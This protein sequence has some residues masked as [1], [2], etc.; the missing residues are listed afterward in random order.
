MMPSVNKQRIPKGRR[1][2]EARSKDQEQK[3]AHLDGMY[4]D[5]HEVL[6]PGLR[7]QDR[8]LLDLVCLQ[9]YQWSVLHPAPQSA[10]RMCSGQ[11]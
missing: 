4:K 11:T 3:L 1:A 9:E 2:Q 7:L 6:D 5:S 10:H 8:M